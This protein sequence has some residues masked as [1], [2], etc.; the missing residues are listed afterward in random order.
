[1]EEIQKKKG[2]GYYHQAEARKERTVDEMTLRRLKAAA[3]I[4]IGIGIFF[5][6]KAEQKKRREIIDSMLVFSIFFLFSASAL[7]LVSHAG[8]D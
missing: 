5:K 1:M 6:H 7:F 2:F 3:T 4:G 8:T